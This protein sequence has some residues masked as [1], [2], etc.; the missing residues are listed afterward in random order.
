MLALAAAAGADLRAETGAPGVFAGA[1]LGIVR[2]DGDCSGCGTQRSTAGKVTLGYRFGVAG[3]EASWTGYRR[4]GSEPSGDYHRRTR[5][6]GLG[7][8]WYWP[9]GPST[10]AVARVGGADAQTVHNDG[11]KAR[12]LEATGGLGL[13]VDLNET[14]SFGLDWD[15]STSLGGNATHALLA[16]L[17]LRF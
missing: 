1:G 10:Q 4:P 11:T 6:V 13:L 12:W 3:I 17:R 15:A 14:L 7:A 9:L 2:Y 16:G 8:A 5:S